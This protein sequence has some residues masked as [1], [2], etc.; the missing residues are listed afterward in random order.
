MITF[1]PPVQT[2]FFCS[3]GVFKDII[4]VILEG[5]LSLWNCRNSTRASMF[6]YQQHSGG[7]W[8]LITS[9]RCGSAAVVN[10]HG[11]DGSRYQHKDGAGLQ[12]IGSASRSGCRAGCCHSAVGMA[13]CVVCCS[14]VWRQCELGHHL[15]SEKSHDLQKKNFCL[16]K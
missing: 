13:N 15:R 16:W 6:I 11:P 8:K 10:Q 12:L 4:D 5:L 14:H 7:R 2:I 3:S 1:S 9:Y